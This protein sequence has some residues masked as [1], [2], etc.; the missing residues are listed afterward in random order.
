MQSERPFESTIDGIPLGKIVN[1]VIQGLG[2]LSGLV[3][4]LVDAAL[5][6]IVEFLHLLSSGAWMH[7]TLVEGDEKVVQDVLEIHATE[8]LLMNK[9]LFEHRAGRPG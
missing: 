9:Y 1:Q 8:I 7:S 6:M 3:L 5:I 4:T 2:A